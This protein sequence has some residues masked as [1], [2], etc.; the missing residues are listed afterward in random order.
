MSRYSRSPGIGF[1]CT[2]LLAMLSSCVVH[3]ESA[4]SAVRVPVLYESVADLPAM[5]GRNPEE[6]ARL[7][8]ELHADMVFRC[9]FKWAPFPNSPEHIDP[10]FLTVL[11]SPHLTIEQV[12]QRLRRTGR[13]YEHLEE[14]I[15][16]IKQQAP[17][18][19]FVGGIPSQTLGRVEFNPMTEQ[20]IPQ[21]RTWQMALDPS[22]WDI[23]HEGKPVNRT[24]FQ[25]WWYSVHPYGGIPQG[26]DYDLLRARAYFPDLTNPGFQVLMLSWAQRQIRAGCDA[27]W[28]DMLFTQAGLMLRATRSPNHPAVAAAVKAARHIVD[29][30]HRYGSSLGRKV[31][32]GSWA[33]PFVQMP[34]KTG[35]A[36]PH[37]PPALDFVTISPKAEEIAAQKPDVERWKKNLH[38][39]HE[40]Y[41]DVPVFAFIDWAFDRSPLVTFTQQLTPEEQRTFLRT[42]DET[43]HSWGVHFVYPLHGGAMGQDPDITKRLSFGRY[44]FYDALAPEFNTYAMIRKLT[45]ARHA[46]SNGDHEP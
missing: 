43:L 7:L 20:V 32:V 44:G 42:M 17:G 28:I 41:G 9:F 16:I 6:V 46:A 30:I 21:P 10:A 25:A 19:L 39:I 24:A 2:C 27:I 15:A 22:K 12:A 36:F 35:K 33:G 31:F 4:L 45:A 14:S 37:R 34:L 13:Y 18:L 38:L 23:R 29:E 5:G 3:A 40:S 11:P 1:S 8:K 26:A